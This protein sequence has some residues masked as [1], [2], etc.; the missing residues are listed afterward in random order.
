MNVVGMKVD[1]YGHGED[2][3]AR[4]GGGPLV[5]SR[6]GSLPVEM[7]VLAAT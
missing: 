2:H 6:S 4:V 5:I 7:G 1:A 3:I